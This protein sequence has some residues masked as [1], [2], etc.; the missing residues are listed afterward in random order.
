MTVIDPQYRQ[1]LFDA[2]R[3]QLRTERRRLVDEREAFRAFEQ[4]IRTLDGQCTPTQTNPATHLAVTGDPRGLRAVQS[5]YESTV[6]AVPHYEEEYDESFTE[7]VTGEFGPQIGTLLTQ[8]SV[9]DTRAKQTVLGAASQA[10]EKREALITALEAE[11]ESLVPASR[12]LCSV[13]DE[14]PEYEQ[15]VFSDSQFG[16]LDAYRSRL[17]VLEQTCETVVDERQ[18]ALVEQRG[19]LSLPIEGPDIPTYLYQ[20]METTYPVV[21]TAAA[22][23]ERIDTLKTEVE[24]ALIYPE[25]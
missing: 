15:A 3:H 14:L 5:A 4:H 16:T 8:G 9:L 1:E 10:Q 22:L 11:E 25:W 21:S 13:V 12:E 2:A 19:Q 6:M 23:L 17:T 20:H 7:H 18:A 24:R